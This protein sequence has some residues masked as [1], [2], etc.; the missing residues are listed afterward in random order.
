MRSDNRSASIGAGERCQITDTD[1]NNTTR[2]R[3]GTC[4]E[5]GRHPA[6]GYAGRDQ[7]SR[8]VERQHG[9]ALTI[10]VQYTWHIS[11]QEQ[12]LS[13]Q[14]RSDC[15]GGI[16][17]IH[18]ERPANRLIVV[19]CDGRDDREKPLPEQHIDESPINPCRR[20]RVPKRR[21]VEWDRPQ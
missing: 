18:V 1:A 12:F 16:V 7:F 5:L 4:I 21:R 8:V 2:E 3:V 17:A 20:A 9:N 11:Q 15:G 10:G 6:T 14:R 19:C 13:A